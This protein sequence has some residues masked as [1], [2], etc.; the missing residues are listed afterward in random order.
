MNLVSKIKCLKKSL[1][2]IWLVDNAI[3]NCDALFCFFLLNLNPKDILAGCMNS[4]QWV[5]PLHDEPNSG[6]NLI[7]N[8]KILQ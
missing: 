4:S 2:K 5:L 6:T 1:F 8:Q 3:E 7:Q